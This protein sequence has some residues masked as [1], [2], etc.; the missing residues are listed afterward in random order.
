[1]RKWERRGPVGGHV[2]KNKQIMQGNG[3]INYKTISKSFHRFGNDMVQKKKKENEQN[4]N[5]Y[6]CWMEMEMFGNS[7]EFTFFN[8]VVLSRCG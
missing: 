2:F 3:M 7:A 1:V 5:T 6:T 4:K 8:V